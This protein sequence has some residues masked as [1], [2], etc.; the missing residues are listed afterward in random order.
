MKRTAFNLWAFGAIFACI[1]IHE[2]SASALWAVS[3]LVSVSSELVC[4]ICE[5]ESHGTSDHSDSVPFPDD[6]AVLADS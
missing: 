6:P 5:E 1:H 2:L 3:V 4:Q